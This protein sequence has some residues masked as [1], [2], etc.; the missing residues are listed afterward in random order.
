MEGDDVRMIYMA[1]GSQFRRYITAC[2]LGY[3]EG[4]EEVA[5]G[6]RFPLEKYYLQFDFALNIR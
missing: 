4:R 5:F 6:T 1:H 2:N 3:D